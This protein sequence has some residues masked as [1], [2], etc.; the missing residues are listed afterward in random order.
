[1]AVS[2]LCGCATLAETTNEVRYLLVTSTNLALA[3]QPLADYRSA[4][5]TPA[6]VVTVEGIAASYPG[7]DLP[8][9]IRNCA[10]DYYI[11]RGTHYLA[12]GGDD[13]IVPS[14]YCRDSPEREIQPADLYY[15]DMDGASW[16][17]DYDGVY[18]T[19][20][21][22]GV[23]ELTPELAFGRIAVRTPAEAAAYITKLAR[24]ESAT[25]TGFA[26]SMLLMG[27]DG[28][29]S[30]TWGSDRPPDLRDHDP[31]GNKEAALRDIYATYIQPGWQ[32][33][34]LHLFTATYTS[35]DT[36]KCGDYYITNDRIREQWNKGVHYVYLWNH[37]NKKYWD[38]PDYNSSALFFH[39]EAAKLT[40]PIPSVV[41]SRSCGT[42]MYDYAVDPCLGE[43][44]IRNSNGGAIAFFGYS[45][46][47]GGRPQMQQVLTAIFQQRHRV[48]G[49][50][51]AA[52]LSDLAEETA[53]SGVLYGQ[54]VMC[55]LGDP[56]CKLLEDDGGKQIQLFSPSG[57]E[58]IELGRMETVRWNAAGNGF[59]SNETVRIDYS[60]DDGSTWQPLPG[61]G[62]LP[63]HA[64]SF[65]WDTT[66]YPA[67][68]SYRLRLVSS[69]EPHASSTSRRAFSVVP[70]GLLTVASEPIEK[71][72]VQGDQ[73]GLTRYQI[74]VPIGDAVRLRADAPTN[75]AFCAWKDAS[76][77][78]IEISTN[79]NIT[80]N[81]PIT[82][83]ACYTNRSA[84]TFYYVNDEVG[85]GGVGPG[86]DENDG[87]TPGTPMRELPALLKKHPFLCSG[88]SVFVSDGIY[89]GNITI[90]TTNAGLRIVGAGSDRTIIS[91]GGTNRCLYVSADCELEAIC[92]RDGVAG[93]GGGITCGDAE[94]TLR[95]CALV[96][97]LADSMRGGAVCTRGNALLRMEDCLLA[98]NE[99][100]RGGAI[101]AFDASSILATN[102]NFSSNSASATSGAI[103]L[104]GSET[105]C[106]LT[107]CVFIG[108]T[109]GNDA[110]AIHLL[111]G[112]SGHVTRCR[113]TGNQGDSGGAIKAEGNAS[114]HVAMCLA[115]SNVARVDGGALYLNVNSTGV[116]DRCTLAANRA[117]RGGAVCS[118][119]SAALYLSRSVLAQNQ[120]TASG[121][122]LC[123]LSAVPAQV[124]YTLADIGYSGQGNLVGN[125]LFSAPGQGD[126]RLTI[127]SPG[128]DACAGSSG[129]ETDLS[130]VASPLDA[131]QDGLCFADMGA[132]EFL[133]PDSDSDG[134]GLSDGDE[135]AWG[136]GLLLHDSDG[137]GM[138]DGA[139]ARAA[140]DPKNSA[141]FFAIT[142]YGKMAASSRIRWSAKAGKTY[143]VET[144]PDLL[145]WSGAPAGAGAD[146]QSRQTALTNG[147]LLYVEP[148]PMT[149]C[150]GFYRILLLDD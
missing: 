54:Y 23:T 134:D 119:D 100:W 139:E 93:D 8:E 69:E 26:R 18:G 15:A 106:D 79:L 62:A 68:R 94:L 70:V 142:E 107:D 30:T 60:L 88:N 125:P 78:I 44:F 6:E 66:G 50:A 27:G 5:G 13:H 99:A 89:A 120:A 52:A 10:R 40:N 112:S 55:L 71:L 150:G 73:A 46:S 37:G 84:G 76:G 12:I 108:N 22:V 33:V 20:N 140:T 4:Q 117:N 85:D 138:K 113:F 11:N 45:R 148:P 141:D 105:R 25:P 116:V 110:G 51:L 47:V 133:N 63:W 36:Q 103:R 137:D 29:T 81:G 132:F 146:Q 145:T 98:Q 53:N 90:S 77:E 87:L 126:Y 80:F 48:L 131:N 17:T 123:L 34:P 58:V 14:R 41:F 135:M 147:V 59:G 32:A 7:I 57:C 28:W 24:Y 72:I 2:V 136:T 38:I 144:S 67:S 43:A 21:D 101:C 104:W 143:Q 16:D 1:M 82:V 92:L 118:Q 109:A 74:T 127:A 56:A 130:G 42:A 31:V 95:R 39:A 9:Q 124:N 19:P 64:C 49:E 61:A 122:N 102:C 115:I 97:N 75:L 111:N 65:A 149:N 129:S 96:G 35:W 3:F 121:T 91:A 83:C 128:L 86:D 114:V